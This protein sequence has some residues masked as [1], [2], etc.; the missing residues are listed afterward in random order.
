ME[1]G[2]E[3]D[4]Q[5]LSPEDYGALFIQFAR[6][7]K[8][9]DPSI[10]LGGPSFQTD[11][12]SWRYWPNAANE[13]N[14]ILRF[15]SYLDSHGHKSDFSFF[16]FEWYPFDNLNEPPAGQLIVQPQL[17]RST[18]AHS[19]APLQIPWYMTEYGYS[20]FAG[21]PEVTIAGALMNT[22]IAL[23]FLS[24]GGRRAYLYGYE[25]QRLIKEKEPGATYGNLALFLAD[26]E[27][28]ARQPFA[29]YYA[30]R[31]LTRIWLKP[32][33]APHRIVKADVK[34]SAGSPTRWIAAYAAMRPDGMLS[35]VLLNKDPWRAHHASVG[36]RNAPALN[37]PVDV[38][39]YSGRQYV[40][41]PGGV[42]G[43]AEPDKPPERK[44][45][46]SAPS[47][48]FDLPPFSITVLRWRV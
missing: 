23:T 11:I 44:S 43:Y 15:L 38:Y 16:S 22:D 5:L 37:G 24:L 21:Q 39:Q 6:A 20:A 27:G 30:A 41:H 28:Q 18:L 45:L 14:W 29:T 32:G 2:E 8:A 25:P 7:L 12:G 36:M 33:V 10:E 1:L 40:W 46:S 13:R 26:D 4:G 48:G 34:N 3:P 17:M 9:V 42:N 31:L 35:V 19:G 47:D